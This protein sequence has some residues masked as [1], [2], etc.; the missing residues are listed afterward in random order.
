VAQVLG[1]E[2][3]NNNPNLGAV[4][5]VLV[6]NNANELASQQDIMGW[7]NQY[8]IYNSTVA[9]TDMNTFVSAD[10]ECTFIMDTA[11]MTIQWKECTCKSGT[12]PG[13]FSAEHGLAL[14]QST[15]NP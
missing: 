4:F 1:Q 11:T 12:C 6:A 13:G 14:L 8:L 2:A 3:Q 5:E 9:T 10:R 15:Y 7:V